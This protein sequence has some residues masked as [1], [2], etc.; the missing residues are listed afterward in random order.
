M[1]FKASVLKLVGRHISNRI[2]KQSTQAVAHQ[3]RTLK[4]LISKAQNTAFGSDHNF[5]DITDQNS[6]AKSVPVT[7]YEGHR[8]YVDQILAGKS[9]VLWPGM[10]K[11]FAKTSGTTSGVKYIPIS[12][13][14]MPYHIQGARNATLNMLNKIKK[15]EVLTGKLIFISGSPILQPSECGVPLGRLSGIVNHEI[16]TWLQGNQM[17]S[18]KTNCIDDWEVKVDKIARETVDKN[19]TLIGG[20]PP[21]VQMYYERL[22]TL[23]GKATI[24]DLFPD[25]GLFVYGGVNYEPYRET[26]N[27]LVGKSVTSLETY[28]ASEGFIAFQDE[29]DNPGLLLNTNGGIYFEFI[30][31]SKVFDESPERLTLIEIELGVD[32]AVIMTTNAGLWSYNIGDTVRFVSKDPYRLIVSGRIKHYISAF[33]EHVIGKEV[34]QAIV[35]TVSRFKASLTEFTVAPQVNPDSGLPYHEWFVEWDVEP[36]DLEKFSNELDVAMQEQNIYYKDLIKDK[37]LRPLVVT[38]VENDGFR[39]YMETQGKLGGQNKVPRLSNDRKI[40]DAL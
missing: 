32:Y 6:Y 30:E 8:R 18:Y 37:V 2:K 23:S 25:F 28:P 34:E 9:D 36:K 10:P 1:A 15:P 31:L 20:I 7:D 13:E 26:L 11:Y 19:M 40:A 4:H 22:L 5:K 35:N 14:S 21:W 12:Q 3:D 17:P 27:Q 39:R 38:S 29:P 33:G 16:P 24:S